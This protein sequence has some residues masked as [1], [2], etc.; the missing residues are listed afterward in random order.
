M[1]AFLK[2]IVRIAFAFVSI[3]SFSS[4]AMNVDVFHVQK[5][6]SKGQRVVMDS[7]LREACLLKM[8]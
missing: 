3:V 2:G 4:F 5:N 8:E 1:K 6:L 7:T